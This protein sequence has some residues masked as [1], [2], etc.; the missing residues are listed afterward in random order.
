MIRLNTTLKTLRKSILATK[1]CATWF[2]DADS[3]L[4]ALPVAPKSSDF[5]PLWRK[6]KYIYI[7]LQ[8]SKCCFCEKPLEG[9]ISQDVEHFRPKAEVRLWKPSKKLLVNGVAPVSPASA[10]TEPGY[11]HLAY[12]PLNYAMACKYCNSML[13]KNYFPINGTRNIGGTNPTALKAE[14]AYLIYPLGDHD[15]DPEDLIEFDGLS[16][17]AKQPAGFNFLRAEVVIELFQLGNA[18]KRR[19]LFKG[20]AY[21]MRLLFLELQGRDNT[22]DPVKKQKHKEVIKS[23]TG[24]ECPYANCMRSFKRL[25]DSDPVKA[26]NYAYECLKYFKRKSLRGLPK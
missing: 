18:S 17:K 2:Q 9:K 6:I 21:L 23:L 16:P 13:K 11:A 1:G 5:T 4:A 25:Y 12:H 26:E 24:D 22:A 7:E 8:H 10:A 20:R 3:V 15:D 19:A 14:Q